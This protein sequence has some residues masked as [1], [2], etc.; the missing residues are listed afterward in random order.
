[1]G[2]RKCILP[3]ILDEG[4]VP[5]LGVERTHVRC[6]VNVQ[7]KVVFQLFQLLQTAVVAAVVELQ[8][9]VAELGLQLE[10]K[11]EGAAQSNNRMYLHST[12]YFS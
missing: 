2:K 5:D 6:E 11:L 10:E 1:M 9:H 12:V 7:Q 8:D 4:T 3:E